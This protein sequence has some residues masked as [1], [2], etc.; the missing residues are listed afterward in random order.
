MSYI[1][2]DAYNLTTFIKEVP[3]TLLDFIIRL[4]GAGI[5]LFLASPLF[6]AITFG[7]LLSFCAWQY[8]MFRKCKGKLK[9]RG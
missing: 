9:M 2:T 1:T 5:V 8:V 3:E 4:S 6:G 7:I